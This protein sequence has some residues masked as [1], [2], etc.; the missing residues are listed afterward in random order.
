VY[1]KKYENVPACDKKRRSLAKGGTPFGFSDQ[2]SNTCYLN[3]QGGNKG[4]IFL[5]FLREKD[6][7]PSRTETGALARTVLGQR[8]LL[9]ERVLR[10]QI[11][12]TPP[13]SHITK[14]GVLECH[15]CLGESSAF[16]FTPKGGE[17]SGEVRKRLTCLKKRRQRLTR[18]K[19][20]K[21]RNKKSADRWE[22]QSENGGNVGTSGLCRSNVSSY[23]T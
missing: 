12:G 14:G 23:S 21:E 1:A 17:W 16:L 19:L 2:V 20:P 9:P 6:V 13:I 22:W 5:V 10:D 3:Y 8:T 4:S 18:S 11:T 15:L 7:R